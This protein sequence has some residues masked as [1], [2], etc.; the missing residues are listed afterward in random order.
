MCVAARR[1]QRSADLRLQIDCEAGWKLYKMF[2]D[3]FQYINHML[4]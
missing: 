2:V 3:E 4:L 1:E